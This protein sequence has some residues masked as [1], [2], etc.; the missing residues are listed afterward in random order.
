MKRLLLD[1]AG[2][3]GLPT[4]AEVVTLSRE[5]FEGLRA[6]AEGVETR[7]LEGDGSSARLAEVE[8]ALVEGERRAAEREGAYRS[9]LRDREVATALVGRPLVPGAAQQLMK[10]WREEFDVLEDGGELRVADRQG[11]SVAK[12]VEGW[13]SGPEYAHFCQPMTRGGTAARGGNAPSP[14]SVIAPTPKTLGDA[15]VMRW[16]EAATRGMV[17]STPVGLGRRR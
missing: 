17:G 9:A 13:L 8:R 10:L 5:E 14:V 4:S 3:G 7:P 16:Q 1:P 11:R 2:G 12:A 6:R 15:A